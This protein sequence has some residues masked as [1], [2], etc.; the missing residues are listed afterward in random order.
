MN[1]MLTYRHQTWL[2]ILFMGQGSFVRGVPLRVLTFGLFAIGVTVVDVYFST[3]VEMPVGLHEVGGAVVG[4]IL[5]FRT[6]MAYARFW[7]AR[8]IWGGLVNTSRNL[9][10]MLDRYPTAGGRALV[11]WIAVFNHSLRS[12]LRDEPSDIGDHGLISP[13]ELAWL[14]TTPNQVLAAADMLSSGIARLARKGH[15]D[16]LMAQRA[17]SLVGDLVNGLGACERIR[18]TPTPLGY[19]LLIERLVAVY[20]LSL[21]FALVS[22]A[23]WTTPLLA[24]FISYPILMLDALAI[25][26]DDPF[27]HDPNDIALSKLTEV[28]ERDVRH[29]PAPPDDEADVVD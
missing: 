19:V 17:E 12:R 4:L 18:H 5:A 27:G 1:L 9:A 3:R 28:I 7:E 16:P 23:G 29:E 6:N 10:R 2:H 14:Q 8:T 15:F 13:P 22:R 25:E 21:P 20:L 11:P 24:V 26:L